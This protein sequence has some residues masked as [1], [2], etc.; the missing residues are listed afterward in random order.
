VSR[1]NDEFDA[2]VIG[3]GHNGLAA[4]CYLADAGLDVSVLE[5]GS[6]IGG[7]TA[8]GRP[9]PEAPNHVVNYCAV[10]L[11]FFPSCPVAKEL[12]LHRYG[13]RTVPADPAYVYLH[14]DGASLALWHDPKRTADEIR[15]FSEPDATAFL[16]YAEFLDALL[17]LAL[18]VMSAHPIHPDFRA[19]TKV[20][21]GAARHRKKLRKIGSFCF[22]SGAE[23]IDCRFQHPVIRSA[24]YAL[25]AGVGP[26][27]APGTSMTHLGLAFLHRTGFLRPVGGMQSVPDALANRL[28]AAGGRVLTSSPVAEILVSSN[29]V[30][31]VRLTDGK[32][33]RARHVIATCDPGKA[34]IELLPVT[35]L[36]PE[37]TSR[38]HQ[39]PMNASGVGQMKVDLALSGRIGLSRHQRRRTDD[40]DLRVPSCLIG[41][42][43]NTNRSFRNSSAGLLPEAEDITIWAVVPTALDQSQAPD[44]QDTVYL[45]C[46]AVPLYPRAGWKECR[47]QAAE[48]IV[49]RTAEYFPGIEELE[50]GRW[51]ETPEDMAQ[52]TNSTSACVLHVDF[53]LTRCGPLRPAAGFGGYSLPVRGLYLGGS[54]SHPGGGVTGMP[55]RLSAYEVIRAHQPRRLIRR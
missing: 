16:E 24:L 33:I 19:V 53:V 2:V 9:I 4:A 20:T 42:P 46:P 31:G 52:R 17:D 21:R 6:E 23:V 5:A 3:A 7:M 44:G 14:P 12:E 48:A 45:Y 40:L 18:P 28:R 41:S 43:D 27:D 32:C 10:D 50:L 51:V 1:R 36:S 35:A 8:S 47:G 25:G 11:A 38:A 55:G 29:A 54:G 34:L 15:R 39:I 13:L 49:A 37:M 22:A 26:I 30:E